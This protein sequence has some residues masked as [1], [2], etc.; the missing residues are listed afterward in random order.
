MST[1]EATIDTSSNCETEILNHE[2]SSKSSSRNKRTSRTSSLTFS[3]DQ[4]QLI[5]ALAVSGDYASVEDFC[6]RASTQEADSQFTEYAKRRG[7]EK[8]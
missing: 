3:F 4:F 6:E 5:S 1:A 2:P 8:G 7:N